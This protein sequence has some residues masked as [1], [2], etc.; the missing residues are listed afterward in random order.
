MNGDDENKPALRVVSTNH[1]LPARDERE[2]QRRVLYAREAAQR[3]LAE[4]A[5]CLLRIMAGSTSASYELMRHFRHLVE[6]QDDLLQVSGEWMTLEDERKALALPVAD[7]ENDA[8]DA[9][10]RHWERKEALETIV[11][12]ALRLAA[13]QVLG[14]E[15][16]FGGKHS[17]RLIEQGISALNEARKPLPQPAISPSMRTVARQANLTPAADMSMK[18][19]SRKPS[20]FD[21]NDLK[22]LRKAIKAGDNK[23]IAELTAKIGQPR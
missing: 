12:G 16:H 18:P 11:Q 14:E 21:Q 9:Q 17:T 15:P 6:R 13:H 10:Y 5:A 1:D 3:A 22:E 7:L 20:P 23:R 2:N 4:V 8:S 19:R